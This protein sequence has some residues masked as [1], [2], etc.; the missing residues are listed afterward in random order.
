MG[1]RMDGL[2]KHSECDSQ[3]EGI[4]KSSLDALFSSRRGSPGLLMKVH[5]RQERSEVSPEKRATLAACQPS[6]KLYQILP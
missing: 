1:P 2:A 3:N 5:L 4:S 6:L